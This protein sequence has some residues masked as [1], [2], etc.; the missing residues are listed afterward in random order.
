MKPATAQIADGYRAEGAAEA[1]DVARSV[2]TG[3]RPAAQILDR[4][5]HVAVSF[6]DPVSR[7]PMLGRAD[8][9]AVLSGGRLIRTVELGRWR[10]SAS[11]SSRDRPPGAVARRWLSPPSRWR[12]SIGSVGRVLVLLLVAGPAALLATA[13]G[14]RWLARR[15]LLPMDRMTARAAAIDLERIEDRLVV[16]RTGDEV[17]H[18]ATTL[19]AMLDRIEHGVEEQHRLV[20]D[21]SHELR[22]PLAAMRAEIDVS[23]RTDDLPLA[24]RLGSRERARRGRPDERTRLTTCSCSPAWTRAGWSCWSSRSTCTSVTARAVKSLGP[25]ARTRSVT[26]T[27]GGPTAMAVGDADRLGHA[28]RNLV[29]NAIE[30]S[31]ADGEVVVSPPGRPTARSGSRCATTG[32]ASPPEVRERIFD[33]FFRADPSRTRSTG[34]GGL[35]LAITREIASA[36]A[37]RVWV[38]DAGASGGSAFSLALA[39]LEAPPG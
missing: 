13:L 29:E 39:R 26:L 33:R 27:L 15:A 2:L 10:T 31:P 36:H 21:A 18:L 5:G 9:A 3:E 22:T 23:L 11:G 7:A 14:G 12:P 19:N 30:F 6:G 20:A 25:L 17:A 28:L 32:P 24:A 1:V 38:D 4:S 34:G 8:A 35:G 16:P 37:A